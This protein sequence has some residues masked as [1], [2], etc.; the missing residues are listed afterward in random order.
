MRPVSL[1]SILEPP[2][3]S[4][5]PLGRDLVIDTAVLERLLQLALDGSWLLTDREA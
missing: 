2:R 1:V 5:K 3:D 4:L